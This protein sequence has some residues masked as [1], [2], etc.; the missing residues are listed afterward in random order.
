MRK[1]LLLAAIFISSNLFATTWDEPWQD[2]VVKHAD[3]FVKALIKSSDEQ[4]GLTIDII[5][6]IAGK[7]LSGEIKITGF[8]LLELCSSTEG[9]GTEF[10]FNTD[11][12]YFFIQK[13]DKGNYCISTPTSGYAYVRDS[14]VA[15]TYRHSYH[16]CY[17]PADV[18]EKTMGAIFNHYHNLPYDKAFIDGY[19]NKYLALKPTGFAQEEIE[20]FFAQ[21]VALETIHHLRLT[22]HYTKIIPFL[23]DVSNFHNQA[24]AARALVAY[25]TAESKA[26]LLK[27]IKEPEGVNLVKVIAVWTL[28]AFKPK[29]LK[30]QL[31][32]IAKT[33]N[34]D[35]NG[36][37]GDIM[38]PRICTYMPSA[39]E[40][41]EK[42]IKKL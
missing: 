31:S 37:G 34:D 20:T 7:P 25:N 42:L 14:T 30:I 23:Q 3:H 41:I 13:N 2:D 16:K 9:H 26:A 36:F 19:I 6:T 32:E 28:A 8:Y 12:A 5:K 22:G 10:H 27:V 24:S 29:E 21:H 4:K 11:E 35:S 33:S 18:Y 17:V 15:A 40:A 38:D 1:S 39:K